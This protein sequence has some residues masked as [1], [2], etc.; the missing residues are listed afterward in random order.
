VGLYVERE[1]IWMDVKVIRENIP[2]EI[3]ALNQWV[4]WQGEQKDNG[5]ITKRPVN[6]MTGK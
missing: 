3:K 2:N 6:P 5:K 1:N 4:A